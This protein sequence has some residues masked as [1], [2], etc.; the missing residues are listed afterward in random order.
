M[1][2]R[3]IWVVFV[4]GFRV[5]IPLLTSSRLFCGTFFFERARA[6]EPFAKH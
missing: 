1:I 3:N 2:M 6:I 4:Y 5:V